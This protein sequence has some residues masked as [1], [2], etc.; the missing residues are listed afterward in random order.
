MEMYKKTV[1]IILN[2]LTITVQTSSS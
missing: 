1:S 2:S